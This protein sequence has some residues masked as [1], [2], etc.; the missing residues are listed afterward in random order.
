MTDGRVERAAL[1]D[2]LEA[3]A[4]ECTQADPHR[5]TPSVVDGLAACLTA[6][7]DTTKYWCTACVMNHAAALLRAGTPEGKD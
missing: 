5:H 4:G 2:E 3:R 6:P 7:W 1:A